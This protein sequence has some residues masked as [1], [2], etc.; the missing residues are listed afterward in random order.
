MQGL[1]SAEGT[2]KGS[3]QGGG[4]AMRNAHLLAGALLKAVG[5]EAILGEGE[6]KQLEDWERA[7][8]RARGR[9]RSRSESRQKTTP[10]QCPPPGG[11]RRVTKGD[12]GR[13]EDR[14]VGDVPAL[15]RL[16]GGMLRTVAAELLLL[17]DEVRATDKADDIV[18]TK[19]LQNLEHVLIDKLHRGQ[20]GHHAQAAPSGQDADERGSQ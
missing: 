15:S 19:V 20:V 10:A 5:G 13:G 4:G 16:R 8:A 3:S 6:V 18:L 1:G 12:R 7:R 14:Q 17:L 2:A 9:T 11:W